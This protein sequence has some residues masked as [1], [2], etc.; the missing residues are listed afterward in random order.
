MDSAQITFSR[1]NEVIEIRLLIGG[2]EV[3]SSAS[4]ESIARELQ[5]RGIRFLHIEERFSTE[6]PTSEKTLALA[7]DTHFSEPITALKL[8]AACASTGEVPTFSY[9]ERRAVP[10]AENYTRVTAGVD[11]P[12]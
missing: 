8:I 1:S 5:I 2:V 9:D 10:R 6:L 7:A 4:Q 12:A 11:S 3:A